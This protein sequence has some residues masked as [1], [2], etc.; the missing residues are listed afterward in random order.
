[1]ISGKTLP[2]FKPFE[3]SVRAGGYVVNRFLTGIR[4]QEYYF[5]T[6]AGREGLIDTAVK[7]SRSGY[8]Q[9]C[10]IKGMEGLRVEYDTSVRDSDGSLVQFLYGEDGLD[11]TKHKYLND[12]KFQAENFMS[13]FQSLNIAESYTEVY[14]KDATEH[15]KAAYKKVRKTGNVA[16]MDPAT[17][18]YTPGSHSGS[19]SENFYAAKREVSTM[20]M[21]FSSTC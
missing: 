7:T 16:A 14:S 2:C 1:M 19:T 8:L 10:I 17:A 11:P 9:R 4:P 21:P 5:H 6:M 20:I 18:V 3:T 13:M 15:T 12:F